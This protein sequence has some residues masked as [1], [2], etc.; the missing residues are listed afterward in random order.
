[1]TLKIRGLY[2]TLSL[3]ADSD[4]QHKGLV[5]DTQHSNALLC[6]YASRSMS[7]FIYYHAEYRYAECHFAECRY[8]ECRGAIITPINVS[9][10]QP[11]LFLPQLNSSIY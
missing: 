7:C 9:C 3:R 4:T 11:L 5:C 6:Y 1:V 2:V 10:S 8:A